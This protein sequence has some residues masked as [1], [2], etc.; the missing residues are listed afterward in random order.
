METRGFF[1]FLRRGPL[2]C[3]FSAGLM[4]MIACGSKYGAQTVNTKYYPDCYKPIAEMRRDEA[5]LK[6]NTAAGAVVGGVL[7]AV[8]G[9]QKAGKE[10]AAIGAFS[11]AIVGGVAANLLTAQIQ[12]KD[13]AERFAAYSAAL[14]QDIRGLGNA[15]AAASLTN[16]CYENSYKSLSQRYQA[17]QISKNEMTARLKE[18]RDGTN[19]ANA[20]LAK[21]SADIAQNQLVYNDIPAAEAKQ[22]RKS[23]GADELKTLASKSMRVEQEQNNLQIQMK[24]M[25]IINTACQRDLENLSTADSGTMRLAKDLEPLPLLCPAQKS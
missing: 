24:S 23:L 12:Q 6:R 4:A 7:G 14:D 16:K 5:A 8:I 13:Q 18:L 19:D 10:G 3:A 21:F 15:V 20:V 22:A 2:M 9:Y 1:S 17:G 25:Q 11:G